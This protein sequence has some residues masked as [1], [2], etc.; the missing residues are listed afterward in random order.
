MIKVAAAQLAPEPFDRERTVAKAC[1]AIEEA[2]RNGAQLVAFPEAFIPGYPYFLLHLP[3]TQI[4]SHVA[5]LYREALQVPSPATDLLAAAARRA[6]CHVVMGLHERQG[7]TLYNSQLFIAP[8]GSV[9]GCR[10]KLMPTSHERMLWGRGDG[11]DLSVYPTALGVLSGLI[12]YEHSNAL[13][14]YAVQ[15]QGAQIHVAGWPG[16]LP[17]INTI[18]DAAA[19]H[20]AFEAQAFVLNVTSVITEASLAALPAES[21][22]K[23]K[24]GGGYTGILAPRGDWLAG[25][26]LE[27]E[28]LLYAELDFALIDSLKSIVDSA[29]HYARPD[30]VQLKLNR[31]P[32]R[33]LDDGS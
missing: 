1:S 25:P 30:V 18:I 3:P 33:P 11:S 17:G 9:L 23:L 28:T 12:C 10:R 24:V 22:D 29:G 26:V 5:T 6:Q 14:R 2:G 13:F 27:G 7:G 8:D 4:N 19:R 16:G 15:A 20:F 31:N 21:R 32:Q